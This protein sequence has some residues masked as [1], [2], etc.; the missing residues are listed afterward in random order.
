M[1][2]SGFSK[3]TKSPTFCNHT[4]SPAVC[5][6]CFSIDKTNFSQLEIISLVE[7]AEKKLFVFCK[8]CGFKKDYYYY[9]K[10]ENS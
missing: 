5:I 1:G 8:K 9:Q 3:N 7:D 10:K 4:K 6:N 2:C